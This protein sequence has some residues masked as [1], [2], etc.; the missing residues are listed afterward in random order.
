MGA[1]T[2]LAEELW[3]VALNFHTDFS[4]SVLPLTKIPLSPD[5]YT[6]HEPYC[7]KCSN[8]VAYIWGYS[9]KLTVIL[10]PVHTTFTLAAMIPKINQS[11]HATIVFP[12]GDF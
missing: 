2:T 8:S 9:I 10:M 1:N 4:Q 7:T 3:R 5:A 11:A 12:Y 6:I